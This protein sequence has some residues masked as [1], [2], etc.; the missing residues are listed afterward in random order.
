M[1]KG[2]GIAGP[3]PTPGPMS[4]RQQQ[5]QQYLQNHPQAGQRQQQPQP[6]QG[7]GPGMQRVSPGVYRPAPQQQ[8]QRMDP[9]QQMK[10]PGGM[11]LQP[12][13]G[14]GQQ[15]QPQPMPRGGGGWGQMLNDPGFGGGGFKG[16]GQNGFDPNAGWQNPYGRAQGQKFPQWNQGADAPEGSP[17]APQSFGG[18]GGQGAPQF[19]D[20]MY[21]YPQGQG[22]N[23]NLRGGIQNTMY[24]APGQNPQQGQGGQGGTS[25]FSPEQ[26]QQMYQKLGNRGGY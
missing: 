20:M 4:A 24:T 25:Q 12:M 17:M 23:M 22:P 6:P 11:A 15:G 5:R 21:R 7:P 18:G 1:K 26:M 8:P 14:G 19:H 9:M 3:P 10:S 2:S 13:A 16:M